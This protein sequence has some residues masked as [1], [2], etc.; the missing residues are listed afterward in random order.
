MKHDI[1]DNVTARVS[2]IIHDDKLLKAVL[3]SIEEVRVSSAGEQYIRKDNQKEK[4]IYRLW[5]QQKHT[6]KT[7]QEIYE[8]ISIQTD[9]PTSTIKKHISK[10]IKGYNPY[11]GAID[12][13]RL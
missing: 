7:M 12:A 5:L 10:Y 8:Y 3:E 13:D 6:L 4:L 1:L 11:I 9:S 2:K